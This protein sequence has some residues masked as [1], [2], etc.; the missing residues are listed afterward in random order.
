MK[1]AKLSL[2]VVVAII[3]V[4]GCGYKLSGAKS[5]LPGGVKTIAIIPFENRTLEPDVGTVMAEAMQREILRRGVVKLAPKGRADAVLRGTIIKVKLDSQAYDPEGFTTAYR[6]KMEVSVRLV[7]GSETIWSVKKLIEEEN[8][9]IRMH[10]PDNKI[11][12]VY[13][14][15]AIAEDVAE[16]I[17]IMMIEGW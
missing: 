4:C 11:R 15:A 8:V 1:Q 2:G 13:A 6:A 7:R 10:I 5:A 12:R 14:L 17:H 3:L 9:S 16:R